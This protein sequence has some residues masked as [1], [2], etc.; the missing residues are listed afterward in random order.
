MVTSRK[1]IDRL[2]IEVPG[3][4]YVFL[5]DLRAGVGKLEAALARCWRTY[6]LPGRLLRGA[7]AART[8]DDPAVVLFTSGSESTPKAVPLSHR[9]LITNVRASLAV[10]QADAAATRCWASC[11]RSTASA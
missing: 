6:L 1:L 2:G 4:E 5:E 3:A 8:P 9:N 11:R 10:L 7:A